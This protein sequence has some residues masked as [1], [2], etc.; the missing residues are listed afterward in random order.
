MSGHPQG[1]HYD[2]GYGHHQDGQNDSYY[3]D[4]HNQAY[5]DNNGGYTDQPEAQHGHHQG[6]DGYYDEA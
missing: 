2:D 3:P 1:G 6:A 5:Y 4:E